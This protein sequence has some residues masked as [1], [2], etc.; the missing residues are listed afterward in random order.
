M[1]SV[2]DAQSWNDKVEM[3]WTCAE[4]VLEA[5]EER[6]VRTSVVYVILGLFLSVSCVASLFVWGQLALLTQTVQDRSSEDK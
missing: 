6:C 4:K 3:V 2:E 1:D 5:A